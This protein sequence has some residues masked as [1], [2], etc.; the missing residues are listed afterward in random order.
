MYVYRRDVFTLLIIII[1]FNLFFLLD[2]IILFGTQD[3]A[4]L[5]SFFCVRSI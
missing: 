5:S 2:I 4:S 3:A 1:F